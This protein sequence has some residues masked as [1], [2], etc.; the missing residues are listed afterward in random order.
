MSEGK[1]TATPG[2][3][4]ACILENQIEIMSAVSTLL[5]YAKPGLVGEGGE[6]DRQRN[7]LY[8]RH[9]ATKAALSSTGEPKP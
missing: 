4:T 5:R 7:D 3:L 8:Q 2:E 6:L 1:S 9:K